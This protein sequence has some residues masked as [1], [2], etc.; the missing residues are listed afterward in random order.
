[1]DLRRDWRRLI[2][3]M[4]LFLRTVSGVIE[5]ETAQLSAGYFFSNCSAIDSNFVTLFQFRAVPVQPTNL[6]S[7][8]Q[9][10]LDFP[11]PLGK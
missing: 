3:G 10:N 11:A 6:S 5:A 4:V 7:F 1:M 8:D 2:C 9:G